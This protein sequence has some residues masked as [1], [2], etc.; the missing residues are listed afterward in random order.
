[1][2]DAPAARC[3]RHVVFAAEK[4]GDGVAAERSGGRDEAI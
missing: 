2:G 4:N 3:L 1:M